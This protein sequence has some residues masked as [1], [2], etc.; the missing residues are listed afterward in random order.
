MFIWKALSMKS[1]GRL[2]AEVGG[3]VLLARVAEPGAYGN[4]RLGRL[5][6]LT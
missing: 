6:G 4:Y 1:S 2:S 5:S 3:L